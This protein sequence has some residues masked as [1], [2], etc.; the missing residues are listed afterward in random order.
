[1]KNIYKKRG[2]R[3]KPSEEKQTENNKCGNKLQ[4]AKKTCS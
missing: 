1:M 2:T 4:Q 3:P